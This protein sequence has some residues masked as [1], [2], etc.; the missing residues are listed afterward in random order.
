MENLKDYIGDKADK[1]LGKNLVLYVYP[2]DN[3]KGCTL[4]GQEF[5]RLLA[6]FET[7]YS[8]SRYKQG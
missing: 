3:T 8:C 1:Y 2:K 7:G 4:E 5:N 6:D